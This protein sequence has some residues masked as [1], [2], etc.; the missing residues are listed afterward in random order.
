MKRII[1]EPPTV[2]VLTLILEI[3]LHFYFPIVKIIPF[4]FRDLG[5]VVIFLALLLTAWQF[6]TMVGK[7]P[8][9]YG[10]RPRTLITSG[11][12]RFTRNAFY[13]SIILISLGVSVYLT[14]LSPF[15]VVVIEFLI[16]D[17][18]FI[19]QE[20]KILEKTLGKDYLDYKKKVHRWL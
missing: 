19:P 16:F 9:P 20:E 12:F 14:S 18:Y 17:N 6:F 7:T 1:V 2:F 15:I 10:N 11:P 8:I 13:L 3:I 5:L 4:Q